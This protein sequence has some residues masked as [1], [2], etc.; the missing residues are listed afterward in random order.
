MPR[1]EDWSRA[2]V[3]AAVSS[4][5]EM[6]RL[7]RE[8]A[9]YNKSAHRRELQES[10]KQRTE[11]SIE[12]KHQNISAVLLDIGIPSIIDGYKPLSNYQDLLRQVVEERLADFPELE[13]HVAEEVEREAAIP[14]VLD[15]LKVLVSK[16]EPRPQRSSSYVRER[17]R[18]D[19]SRRPNYLLREV[20]NRSLGRAGERFVV[21]FERA[22][23]IA[24]GRE[25]LAA[26]VEHVAQTRGDG[27][28]FDVLSFSRDGAE[29]FIEVKT[30]GFGRYTPFFVTPNELSISQ[31]ES[32]AYRLYRLFTFRKDP[33]LFVV[34]GQLDDSFDLSP[35]EFLAR[36][37]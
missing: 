37:S 23:L 7:E 29:R 26:D 12:R 22:R 17:R 5:F 6:L 27:E 19:T 32:R 21:N 36:L 11:G 3:E 35:S 14:E 8:G 24:E 4:Y 30:T 1:G 10:L 28:G 13:R 25:G 18:A 20:R 15:I 2:E 16:P 33:R 34:P 9:P 31:R